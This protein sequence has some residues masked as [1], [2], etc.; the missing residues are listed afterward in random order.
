VLLVIDTNVLL[1]GLF[2]RGPPH[3][4]L[5][6]ARD[7][8]VD[9]VLSAALIEELLDVIAR[10]KFAD[11]LARTSRT[12]ERIMDELRVFVDVVAAPPLPL[13]ICRDPDDDAVLACALA[14]RA[15]LIAS[16]DD[17][18]RALGTFENIPI[19]SAAEALVRLG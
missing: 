17:D 9:L 15:D 6:K 10:P 3:T 1:S 2:W 13:P 16:G 4:L 12:P 18:L 11:I 7:G 14:A 19:I 8:A 5:G